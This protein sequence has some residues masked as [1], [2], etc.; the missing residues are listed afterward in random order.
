ASGEAAPAGREAS[1][2]RLNSNEN[3]YGPSRRVLQAIRDGIS[4]PHRYPDA[5]RREFEARAA[6]SHRVSPD[7]VLI[8]CGSVEVLRVAAQ[9]L[10]RPGRKLGMAAP[11]LGAIGR[12]ARPFGAH[13]V[14]APPHPAVTNDLPA[15]PSSL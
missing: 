11:T 12:F 5:A 1:D 9:A 6:E 15:Q 8:G 13:R 14:P 7:Q 4:N 10:T 3:A 2:I